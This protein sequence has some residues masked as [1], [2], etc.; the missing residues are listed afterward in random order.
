[1][2]QIILASAILLST[3][4]TLAM[5]NTWYLKSTYGKLDT[6][7]STDLSD[8]NAWSFTLGYRFNKFLS[9]EGGHVDLGEAKD[10]KTY[11]GRFS[12]S[13]DNRTVS[14]K[15]TTLGLFLTTDITK[16]FYIGLRTGFQ[17]WDEHYE[18]N[19]TY[20]YHGDYRDHYT[21]E[22]KHCNTNDENDLYYGVSAGWNYN[23]WSL[24]LEHTSFEMDERKPSLSS[25]GLTYNF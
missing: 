19:A 12:T 9:I 10:K 24:S 15:A 4:S 20:S 25:L 13:I 6:D 7:I 17:R 3:S 21:K 23:N 8:P 2:K 16:D 5:E 1:M 22:W 11:Y 18:N 14:T